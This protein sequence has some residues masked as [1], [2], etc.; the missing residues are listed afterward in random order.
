MGFVISS[1][2][3]ARWWKPLCC[4]V[5]RRSPS[6]KGSWVGGWVAAVDRWMGGWLVGRVSEWIFGW[7]DGFVD[8]WLVG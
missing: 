3:V 4:Y 5:Y 2:D 8:A 7:I 1:I 6:E